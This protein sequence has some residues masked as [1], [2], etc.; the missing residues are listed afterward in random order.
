MRLILIMVIVVLTGITLSQVDSAARTGPAATPGAATPVG[1]PTADALATQVAD[2]E[3]TIAAQTWA[4]LE[5]EL[6]VD[7]LEQGLVPILEGLPEQIEL[8][9][10]LQNQINDLQGRVSVL[11]ANPVATPVVISEHPLVGTW[12]IT[13]EAGGTPGLLSFTPDGTVVVTLPGGG[14]GV[15]AW[16]ATGPGTAVAVWVIAN[17][18][19]R[20]AGSTMTALRAVITVDAA[21]Q[22]VTLDY[23]VLEITPRGSVNEHG[24]GIVTGPR[25][26]LPTP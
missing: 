22:T 20:E 5:L 21:G 8:A 14:S 13:S 16:A 12:A 10:F 1:S 25:V 24:S 11:E 4:Q 7:A 15:G 23:E 3:G 9:S 2:L 19:G 18:A 17:T 26:P 6:R